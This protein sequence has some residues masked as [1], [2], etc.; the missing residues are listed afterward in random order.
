MLTVPAGGEAIARFERKNL[1]GKRAARQR[2][3][4]S[5]REACCLVA[6]RHAALTA[7]MFAAFVGAETAQG[8]CLITHIS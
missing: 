3:N 8:I 7:K 2:K 6:S 1:S 4:A 5:S